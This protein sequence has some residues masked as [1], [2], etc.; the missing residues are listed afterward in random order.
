MK[1]TTSNQTWH[2]QVTSHREEEQHDAMFGNRKYDL[3][4]GRLKQQNKALMKM[5][6]A[7]ERQ[8]DLI[9]DQKIRIEKL[10]KRPTIS[11]DAIDMLIDKVEKLEK[12]VI[13]L[14][15]LTDPE[16]Q[17]GGKYEGH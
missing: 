12:Q 16:Y 1:D 15:K 9:N 17:H 5:I 6:S 11:R 10:E 2:P 7:Y 13:R 4:E 3:I 14:S 8:A